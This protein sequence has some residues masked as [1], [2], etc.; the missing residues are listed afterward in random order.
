MILLPLQNFL[1]NEHREIGVLDPQKLDFFIEPSY[2]MVNDDLRV[3][4]CHG[5]TLDGL[6]DAVGPGF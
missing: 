2:V 1:G 5:R 3:T 4:R 6:P